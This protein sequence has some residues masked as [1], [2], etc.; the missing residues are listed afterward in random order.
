M[1]LILPIVF[2]ALGLG[3]LVRRV[4]TRHWWIMGAWIVLVVAYHYIKH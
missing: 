4:E 2:F 1:N 3:L